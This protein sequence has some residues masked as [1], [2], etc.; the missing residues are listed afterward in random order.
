MSLRDL[1]ESPAPPPQKV[2]AVT[3]ALVG[4]VLWVL[5][6]VV[7]AVAGSR[8]ATLPEGWLRVC[9]AGIGLGALMLVWGV[10]HERRAERSQRH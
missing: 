6:T 8:G 2:N 9:L 7:A 3:M 10:F 4:T 1:G 5:G